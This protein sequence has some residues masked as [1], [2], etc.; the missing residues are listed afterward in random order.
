M[1]SRTR[2]SKAKVSLDV[3][4][5]IPDWTPFL[6]P[7]AK[8][9]SPNVLYIVWDDTGLAAWECF[10]GLIETPNDEWELYHIFEDRSEINDLALV[11]P[12]RL[13]EMIT[14]WFVEAAKNHVFPLDDRTPLEIF[15]TERPSISK[16]RDTYVY[17][18]HTA[19]VPE[20]VVA[21]KRSDHHPARPRRHGTRNRSQI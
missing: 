9:D 7:E 17:Y 15:T 12:E 2:Q 13:K 20:S 16:L 6:P 21:N 18:P 11:H 1:S 5:S 3:R 4:E 19:E 14:L 10:G 8:A